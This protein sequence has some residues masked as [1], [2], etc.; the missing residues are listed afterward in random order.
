MERKPLTFI[1][2][3]GDAVV[4]ARRLS[5][6]TVEPLEKLTVRVPRSVYRSAKVAAALKGQK[7]QAWVH[8]AI[9]EKCE[10]EEIK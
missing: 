5:S 3:A 6:A 1:P 7:L 10:R 2:P 4:A 8:A 9:R